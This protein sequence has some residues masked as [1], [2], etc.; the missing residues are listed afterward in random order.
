MAETLTWKVRGIVERVVD[1]DTFAV[2]LDLGWGIYR[3]ETKGCACAVRILGYN[4]PER[5]AV[6]WA[7]ATEAL[8]AALPV[9]TI[10]WLESH[11]LEKYG[12]ALC[13]VIMLD[14][15]DLLDHLPKQWRV[16]KRRKRR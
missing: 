10:V 4:T 6:D 14:G 8:K 3:S 1:G 7:K 2:K 9:G 5:G 15:S 13:R 12:R 11:Q 16:T